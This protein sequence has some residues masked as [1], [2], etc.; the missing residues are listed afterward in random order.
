MDNQEENL[1][2][3]DAVALENRDFIDEDGAANDA[4]GE[5]AANDADD[6]PVEERNPA[7]DGLDLNNFQNCV[8]VH[9]LIHRYGFGGQAPYSVEPPKVSVEEGRYPFKGIVIRSILQLILNNRA[10]YLQ[11]YANLLSGNVRCKIIAKTLQKNLKKKTGFRV[12]QSLL[13]IA[14]RLVRPFLD[15]RAHS[16][17]KVIGRIIAEVCNCSFF[18]NDE[19][20]PSEAIF[21]GHSGIIVNE[22]SDSYD[23]VPESLGV[24]DLLGSLNYE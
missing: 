19:R 2:N 21:E 13:D 8:N 15:P 17:S 16:V 14:A 5:G 22:K 18:E 1:Q 7:N 11:F 20:P 3:D 10:L 4:D 24:W 12:N 23:D 9:P 6:E